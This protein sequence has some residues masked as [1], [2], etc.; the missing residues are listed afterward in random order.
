[1]SGYGEYEC[2][3]EG[4]F[5]LREEVERGWVQNIAQMQ[6]VQE[7]A[8]KRIELSRQIFF[9][10]FH[11]EQT[12]KAVNPTLVMKIPAT[13]KD[14]PRAPS[15]PSPTPQ[16]GQYRRYLDEAE[17]HGN[18]Q[19]ARTKLLGA[20]LKSEYQEILDDLRLREKEKS[21]LLEKLGVKSVR[22]IPGLIPRRKVSSENLRG[23]YRGQWQNGTSS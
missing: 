17:E 22:G 14:M 19:V 11:L 13:L 1:M 5:R 2:A 10:K 21:E 16:R 4:V 20:R 23:E 9:L 12:L 6:K 8:E 7:A 15:P 3:K 18:L